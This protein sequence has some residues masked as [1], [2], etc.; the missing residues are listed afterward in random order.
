MPFGRLDSAAVDLDLACGR[1]NLQ[2]H[3]RDGLAVDH[4]AAFRDQ[5]L[6]GTPGSDAG[7]GQDFLESQHC[8]RLIAD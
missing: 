7:L 5:L 3:L 4:H 8:G 1:I 2:A 6:R